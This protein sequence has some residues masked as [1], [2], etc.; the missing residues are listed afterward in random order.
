MLTLLSSKGVAK[1]GSAGSSCSSR[2]SIASSAS[3]ASTSLDAQMARS[4]KVFFKDV[5]AVQRQ[6]QDMKDTGEWNV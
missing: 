4:M 2:S 3:A 6:L 5:K 1:P